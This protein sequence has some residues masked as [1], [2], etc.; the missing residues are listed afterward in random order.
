MATQLSLGI[1]L[2]DDATFENFY[3]GQ[4][5]QLAIHA[6]KQFSQSSGDQNIVVWGREGSGLTHLLQAS[7]HAAFV[8]RLDIQYLP[9]TD[10]VGYDPQQVCDGLDQFGLVCLDGFDAVCGNELWEQAIFHLFNRLRD[11]GHRLLIASHTSPSCLPLQ[12]PDLLSRILGSVIYHLHALDD[13]EKSKA[14]QLRAKVRGMEMSAEVSRYILSRAGREMT[15]LFALLNTLDSAS[16]Q[17]QR[18]LTIPFVKE[19]LF[20]SSDRF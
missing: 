6:L 20:L 17:H 18:K 3:V 5:N 4:E 19:V 12:L 1:S 7:C 13:V 11:R 16:L 8:A 9:L 2:R 10:L 14:L 15:D